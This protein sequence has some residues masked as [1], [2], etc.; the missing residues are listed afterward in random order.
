VL[1]SPAIVI[2]RSFAFRPPDAESEMTLR[3][4]R[5]LV[6]HRTRIRLSGELR[7]EQLNDLRTEIELVG[8][9]VTLDLD[10]LNLVDIDAVHFLNACEAQ[11][12][13]T[14]NVSSF[15]REWM[16]QERKN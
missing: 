9:Q 3:M 16:Y 4:E 10:E 5:F 2:G 11:G 15:I 14:L 7:N 13:K 12:V 1:D 8:P 6:N